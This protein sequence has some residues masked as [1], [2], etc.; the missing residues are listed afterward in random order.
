MVAPLLTIIF[1]RNQPFTWCFV[2]VVACRFL[3]RH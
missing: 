3:L 1:R 2:F